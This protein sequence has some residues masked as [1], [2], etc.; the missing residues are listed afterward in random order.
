M[1]DASFFTKSLSLTCTNRST[2][3]GVYKNQARPALERGDGTIYI[4]FSGLRNI[5]SW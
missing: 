3:V 5:E 1:F 4:L 2:A